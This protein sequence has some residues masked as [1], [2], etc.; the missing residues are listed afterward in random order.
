MP[1]FDTDFVEELAFYTSTFFGDFFAKL[2]RMN[3][4]ELEG[5]GVRRKLY[6]EFAE[7]WKLFEWYFSALL[8][9]HAFIGENLFLEDEIEVWLMKSLRLY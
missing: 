4:F 3:S 9:F 8:A 5:F 7:I 2:S 1:F 6:D